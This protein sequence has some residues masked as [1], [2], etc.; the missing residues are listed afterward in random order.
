MCGIFFS[1]TNG[2]PNV[3]GASTKKFL[4]RRGPDHTSAYNKSFNCN[5]I[6]YSL[7]LHC[8]VLALRGALTPQ[9][10]VDDRSILCWNGEAYEIGNKP[11]TGS[12]TRA[13]YE[14]L[15]QVWI[16]TEGQTCDSRT[17]FLPLLKA[18]SHISGPYAMIYL[19][20]ENHCLWFGRDCLGRRSLLLHKDMSRGISLSSV[21]ADDTSSSDWIEV[22]ADGMYVAELTRFG[23][24]YK[25]DAQFPLMHV[26][27]VHAGLQSPRSPYLVSAISSGFF[28]QLKHINFLFRLCH[29][30]V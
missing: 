24:G 10:L 16:S 23:Q 11:A 5:G 3:A 9:P 18:I 20:L 6:Q 15:R 4:N 25:E 12:D 7:S 19:D 2:N 21:I 13:V 27:Y 22:E 8:S 26:P 28:G 1:I 30:Q 14:L 29:F 17:R